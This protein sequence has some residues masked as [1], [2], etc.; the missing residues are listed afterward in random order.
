MKIIN[1][2]GELLAALRRRHRPTGL[3]R[4]RVRRAREL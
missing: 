3:G 2:L 4:A 1:A